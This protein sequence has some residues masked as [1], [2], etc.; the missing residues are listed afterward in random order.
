MKSRIFLFLLSIAVLMPQAVYAEV[1]LF[2]AP[3]RLSLSEASPVQ[4]IRVTNMSKIARAYRISTENLVMNEDGVTSRVDNFD[5]SAKRL[6]RFVPRKF[7]LQPGERQVIRVMGRYSDQV[8]DGDYHVHLEFLEDVG[9]RLEVNKLDPDDIEGRARMMAQVSYATAVPIVMSKGD[10]SAS[11]DLSSFSLG[12]D[13]K[14]RPELSM[15]ILREGN[16]QGQ[17]AIEVEYVRGGEAKPAA[18]RR[19]VPVYREINKRNHTFLLDHLKAEDLVSG[20]TLKIKLYDQRIS[21]KEPVK[22]YDFSIP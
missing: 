9:R 12:K 11:L 13:K 19:Y 8:E 17:A 18:S 3:T 10:V 5:Y 20:A 15:T 22:N 4:E 14:G 7:D 2:F 16:G 6:L 1:A 21:E